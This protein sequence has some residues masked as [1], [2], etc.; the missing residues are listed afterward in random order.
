MKNII[1][2]CGLFAGLGLAL[3]GLTGCEKE[4]YNSY[5]PVF[6]GFSVLPK[7]PVSGDSVVIEAVQSKIGHLLYKAVYTWRIIYTA[8][9]EEQGIDTTITQR[10]VYDANPANPK[11]GIRLP[12]GQPGQL[13]VT[14]R[15][16]YSY[17]GTGIEV[18]SGGTYNDP[19]TGSYGSISLLQSSQLFGICQGR[20]SITVRQ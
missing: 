20:A 10:V 5:V 7:Q 14:F 13:S 2:V 4:D 6:E 18:A 9:D 19:V 8:V 12:E 15:G 1:S 17:S 16:E 3:A 11:V